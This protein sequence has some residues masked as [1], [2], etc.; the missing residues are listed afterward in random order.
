[1]NVLVLSPSAITI[2]SHLE[3][4]GHFPIVYNERLDI[5]FIKQHNIEFAISYRYHHII[6]P[7]V[8]EYL[9]GRIVN[10]HISYLPWNR[11]SDP[12]LWSFLEDT[13]KGITIHYVDSGIDAGNII[14]QKE[15]FFVEEKET[16]ATTYHFLNDEIIRLFND[17]C[18]AILN[19]QASHFEQEDFGT[20]H[21]T[22]DKKPYLYLLSEKGWD[23]PV[24]EVKGKAIQK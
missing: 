15:V 19:G 13:V 8:I 1:M 21:K 11:G 16:L 18:K 9:N 6:A 14:I 24:L 20:I 3:N 12:N 2:I 5:D 10:L 7:E 22:K 4:Q 17:N 23:T